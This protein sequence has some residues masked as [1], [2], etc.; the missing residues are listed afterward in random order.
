MCDLIT[1]NVE[2]ISVDAKESFEEI[3]KLLED[4]APEITVKLE[5]Y[6]GERPIFDLYGIENEVNKALSR[7]V[8]LEIWR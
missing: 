6:Q 5:H 8:K 7:K 2:K 1:P 3:A 4:F